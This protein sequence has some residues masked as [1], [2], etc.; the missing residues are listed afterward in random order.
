MSDDEI[1]TL[2]E[3]AEEWSPDDENDNSD[4]D[5]A[6]S[7]MV[8][9]PLQLGSDVEIANCVA[10]L[11]QQQHGEIIFSEG[12]FWRYLGS[13]WRQFDGHELRLAVHRYDGAT[14]PGTPTRVKLSKTKVDSVLNEMQA[15]QARPEFFSEVL[16]GAET[17]RKIMMVSRTPCLSSR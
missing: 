16:R 7:N 12:Q 3:D 15:I 8:L 13:H 6:G 5:A 17:R 11:L 1:R 9:P 10:Q 4:A 14:V 2:F